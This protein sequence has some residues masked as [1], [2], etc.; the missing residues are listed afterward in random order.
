MSVVVKHELLFLSAL[1]LCACGEKGSTVS[2]TRPFEN[3]K[4]AKEYVELKIDKLDVKSLTK[5]LPIYGEMHDKSDI[6]L[7]RTR[8]KIK[9]ADKRSVLEYIGD[10]NDGVQISAH[11][12]AFNN[13]GAYEPWIKGQPC[14][15]I[16]NKLMDNVMN[17]NGDAFTLKMLTLSGLDRMQE[18][19]PFPSIWGRNT[20]ISIGFNHM[21]FF[22]ITN[23]AKEH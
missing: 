10:P 4:E 6:G 15:E 7:P 22:D 11:C 18:I 23:F 20:K 17:K 14:Y 13:K 21:G 9:G 1:V 5:D 19:E 3:V 8:W 2:T 16:A 12:M